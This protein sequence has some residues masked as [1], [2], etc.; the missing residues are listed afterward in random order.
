MLDRE[1]R[2]QFNEHFLFTL[3][4]VMRGQ[5]Y[6]QFIQQQTGFDQA[7]ATS[8]INEMFPPSYYNYE[9]E[10]PE[11]D[12]VAKLAKGPVMDLKTKEVN[13]QRELAL[14][15][16][17][18]DAINREFEKNLAARPRSGNKSGPLKSVLPQ[19]LQVTTE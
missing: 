2:K 3:S 5:S 18:I 14:A 15:K 1:T 11:K 9:P 7:D 17:D 19:S 12:T 10:R 8:A 4:Q 16:Q 13:L 6:H